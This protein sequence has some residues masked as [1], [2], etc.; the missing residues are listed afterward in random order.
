MSFGDTSYGKPVRAEILELFAGKYNMDVNIWGPDD[1]S[2][3]CFKSEFYHSSKVIMSH[4]PIGLESVSS[5]DRF[6]IAMRFR[7]RSPKDFLT[8][9]GLKMDDELLALTD[10]SG[11]TAL[12]WAARQWSVGHRRRP[13]P[14]LA[15]YGDFIVSLV[16]AGAHVSAIDEHGHSPLMYLLDSDDVPGDWCYGTWSV[17]HELC[18]VQ[19]VHSWSMLL[20]Q[21]GILLTRYIEWENDLLS[22]LDSEH[23]VRWLWR[24][25]HMELEHLSLGNGTTLTMNVHTIEHCMIWE[26]RPPPG[27]FVDNT[28]GLRRLWWQIPE[29]DPEISWQLIEVRDLKSSEP[30]TLS[31][32]SID[33]VEFELSHILF[34]GTQDDH[35]ALTAVYQREQRRADR[36]RNGIASRRRSSSTPPAARTFVAHVTRI[37]HPHSA[38][39]R[40]LGPL[41]VHKCL[42]D[43]QWGFCGPFERASLDMQATCMAGCKRRPDH[44][45]YLAATFLP[46][47]RS[48]MT[49]RERWLAEN[50]PEEYGSE[51]DLWSRLYKR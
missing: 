23:P 24:G 17:P 28:Q 43:A 51:S 44:G 5:Q 27:A 7:G 42:S 26:S 21:A 9:V 19:I 16:K 30:L 45:A 50:F 8:T 40:P 36:C 20:A 48:L 34:G 12:H 13:S 31:P 22:Q 33:N 10:E 3:R 39:Y 4:Q 6:N 32:D 47:E 35:M 14:Q 1:S 11:A 38:K 46:Q 29:D 37:P 2:S 49:P 41:L 25:R 18:P 15:L